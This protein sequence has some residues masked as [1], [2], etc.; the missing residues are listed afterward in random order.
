MLLLGN[1][2]LTS[3]FN[4]VVIVHKLISQITACFIKSVYAHVC[5]SVKCVH[6]YA[7]GY[8]HL[9][10]CI[11]ELYVDVSLYVST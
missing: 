5:Y 8:Y 1:A 7:L 2:D 6:L 10:Y 11:L 3:N 4:V 9:Y